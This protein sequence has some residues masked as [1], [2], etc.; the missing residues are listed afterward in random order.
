MKTN[1]VLS[2]TERNGHI[3]IATDGHGIYILNPTN[4][5]ITTLEHIPGNRYSLPVNSILCLYKDFNDNIWAGS[6]RG[7]LISIKEVGMKTYSDALPGIEYGLSEKVILSIYQD[8]ENKIWIGTDGGGINNFDP[9]LRKFNHI[10]PTWGDKVSSITG[11]DK[12]RLLVSLF[13][14]GIFFF[15]KDTKN[16]NH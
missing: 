8:K 13:S 16:I 6:V 1:V 12:K 9:A 4:G 3:W 2:I 11:V 14:K 15:D 5:E 7:G 10:L